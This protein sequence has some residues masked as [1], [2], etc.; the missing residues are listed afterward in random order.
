MNLEQ[1]P[2]IVP[3]LIW[4]VLNEETVVVSPI[5]GE[6]C[7][8]NEVGTIIWQLLT[9]NYC[10]ADI[11]KY[12]IRYYEVSKEQASLDVSCFLSDLQQ[13][14]LLIKGV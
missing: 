2:K 12:L 4:R 3:N 9:E 8:F 7:V 6:Y 1:V 10:Q 13:R 5:N 14:G 11:E